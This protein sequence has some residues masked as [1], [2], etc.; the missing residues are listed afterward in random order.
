M[1]VKD[2]SVDELEEHLRER[3]EE[4]RNGETLRVV[5]GSTTVATIEPAPKGRVT[6]TRHDP[7]LRLQDFKPGTP[8]HT[9]TVD[10][11]IAER[12]RERSGKKYRP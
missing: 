6:V 1:S 5:D 9:G 2:V 11:L 4:V 3:L 10:W 12:D 8:L 7:T